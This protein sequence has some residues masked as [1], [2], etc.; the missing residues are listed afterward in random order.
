MEGGRKGEK[1]TIKFSGELARRV[2]SPAARTQAEEAREIKPRERM[3]G[4]GSKKSFG[5]SVETFLRPDAR[6]FSYLIEFYRCSLLT[7]LLLCEGTRTVSRM[8]VV[9]LLGDL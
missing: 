9:T 8:L 2:D 3:P 6:N 5:W 1:E 4:R 7:L